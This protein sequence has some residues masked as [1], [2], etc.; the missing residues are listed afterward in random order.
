LE[1]PVSEIIV[2]PDSFGIK[3][4]HTDDSNVYFYDSTDVI[5]HELKYEQ[6][7]PCGHFHLI[8]DRFLYCVKDQ[9]GLLNVID[10]YDLENNFTEEPT[11]FFTIAA[12]VFDPEPPGEFSPRTVQGHSSMENI[13]LVACEDMIIIVDTADIANQNVNIVSYVKSSATEANGKW[14]DITVSEK[15][16][17]VLSEAV[18][19]IEEWD[20][21]T[22]GIPSK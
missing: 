6:I 16:L 22:I 12:S 14:Y 21:T 20:L 15:T 9:E 19:K 7:T 8:N 17:F 18:N 5:I 2:L 11:P 3:Y 13:L 10:V 1:L 4:H